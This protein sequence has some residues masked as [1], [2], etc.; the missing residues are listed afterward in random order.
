MLRRVQV[1]QQHLRHSLC[2]L[3]VTA[4][5]LSTLSA[6]DSG[7][8]DEEPFAVTPQDAEILY[9]YNTAISK[10]AMKSSSSADNFYPLASRLKT[11]WENTTLPG[12]SSKRL[13]SGL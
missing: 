1:L 5:T 8:S 6:R 3:K 9:V 7:S 2:V 10:L 12:K 11:S 13:S 4:W